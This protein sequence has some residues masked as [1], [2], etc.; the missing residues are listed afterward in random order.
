[1]MCYEGH[2]TFTNKGVGALPLWHLWGTNLLAR[3]IHMAH[4]KVL[5]NLLHVFIVEE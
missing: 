3:S 5:G 1:M 2:Y 4:D